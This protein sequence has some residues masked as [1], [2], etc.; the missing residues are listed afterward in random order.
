MD[1]AGRDGTG[2]VVSVRLVWGGAA[3]PSTTGPAGLPADPDILLDRLRAY[4]ESGAD[5]ALLTLRASTPQEYL[6][7][8]ER[9]CTEVVPHVPAG[10][11]A[12]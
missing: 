7:L 5:H 12:A 11:A 2:C 3:S 4:A 8:L 6:S 10:L 9:T 1:D